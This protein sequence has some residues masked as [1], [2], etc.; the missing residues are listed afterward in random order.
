MPIDSNCDVTIIKIDLHLKLIRLSALK[1]L[2]LN[3][4]IQIFNYFETSNAESIIKSGFQATGITHAITNA[5]QGNIHS[6]DP[7]V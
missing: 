1:P 7:Y 2:H 3:T 6:L 5:R 4:P